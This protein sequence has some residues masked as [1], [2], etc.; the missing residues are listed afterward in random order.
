[1]SN[2]SNGRENGGGGGGAGRRSGDEPRGMVAEPRTSSESASSSQGMGRTTS[3]TALRA[4]VQPSPLNPS[5][6]PKPSTVPLRA[7]TPT[8]QMSTPTPKI[9]ITIP[10]GVLPPQPK[11]SLDVVQPSPSIRVSPSPT[12]SRPK[13]TLPIVASSPSRSVSHQI[14]KSAPPPPIAPSVIPP[15][16]SIPLSTSSSSI[17]LAPPSLNRA[18]PAPTPSTSRS[19]RKLSLLPPPLQTSFSRDLLLSDDPLTPAGVDDGEDVI[20]ANV[21]EMLE[22]WDWSSLT[23]LGGTGTGGASAGIKDG[24]GEMERRLADE[25]GAL[26]AV[27]SRLFLDEM[28]RPIPSLTSPLSSGSRSLGQHPLL[29]RSR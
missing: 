7:T 10:R 16:V 20:L 4:P 2:G 3:N 15:S 9:S 17:S 28:C 1:M 29:P 27:R 12:S 8:R 18:S 24:K 22:G 23:T 11:S 14:P 25:L 13:D 5:A 26:E 21:E 6:S 19:H